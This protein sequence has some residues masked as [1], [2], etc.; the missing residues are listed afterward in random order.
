MLNVLIVDDEILDR[1]GLRNDLDWEAYRVSSVKLARSSKEALCISRHFNPDILITDIQMPGM[2]GLTLAKHLKKD[3][4]GLYIIFIS[5]YDNFT[6]AQDALKLDAYDYLLKPIDSDEFKAVIE[7]V[8]NEIMLV[9]YQNEKAKTIE[10]N[11]FENQAIL[12]MRLINGLIIN[13]DKVLPE[14]EKYKSYLGFNVKSNS[15]FLALIHIDDYISLIT[16][17][18]DND[19]MRYVLNICSVLERMDIGF[20]WDLEIA[21]MDTQSCIAIISSDE[22]K[23]D[24]SFN[25]ECV[26][27]AEHMVQVVK[28]QENISISIGVSGIFHDLYGMKD[29][30]DI[31]LK[32]LDNKFI[33]GKGKVHT[34]RAD[35]FV[36]PEQNLMDFSDVDKELSR[37]LVT[38]DKEQLVKRIDGLFDAFEA[39]YTGDKYYFQNL[40][41]NIISRLNITTYEL[42][43]DIDDL[44]GGDSKLIHKLINF[45]TILDIRNWIKN[46]FVMT[47]DFYFN[48]II[49][50]HTVIIEILNFIE[51]NYM[52]E[53]TLKEVAEEMHYTPNYLGYVFIQSQGISFS[54]Y[55]TN[56]RI[57][58]SLSL[59]DN[60]AYKI[61]EVAIKVGYNSTSSFIKRFKSKYGITPS[62]YR[63]TKLPC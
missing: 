48:N 25:Y 33:M 18:D 61:Y 7:K 13:P 58:K 55:L 16:Q 34:K 17:R 47:H 46:I 22:H 20:A 28:E 10:N 39:N 52:R 29:A 56:Y 9:R 53:I 31:A 37:L 38:N 59:L 44:Y 2:D 6:Y 11:Y 19:N 12:N 14:M 57:K 43:I 24:A 21:V 3:F 35:Q 45:E 5:G 23:S 15:L 62:E 50:G 8:V 32:A 30:Y 36:L 42:G 54:E 26:R 1:E 51:K 63:R 27:L 40:C 60:N 41:I 49:H 4:N